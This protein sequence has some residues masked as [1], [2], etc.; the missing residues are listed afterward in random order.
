MIQSVPDLGRLDRMDN[1][2]IT[3]TLSKMAEQLRVLLET[4]GRENPLMIG[5]HTGGYD[6]GRK[7]PRAIIGCG[8]ASG[9]CH[10]SA[11]ESFMA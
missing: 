4:T 5:I 1:K 8:Q 7:K 3:Q 10:A 11:Y 2:E 6:Q 9:K